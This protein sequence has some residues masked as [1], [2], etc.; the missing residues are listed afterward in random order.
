M[1]ILK[2]ID[3]N[4]TYVTGLLSIALAVVSGAYKLYTAT[5]G[6]PVDLSEDK[7]LLI[8][9]LGMIGFRSAMKKQEQ[10]KA[11]VTTTS[12]MNG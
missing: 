7:T 10:P 1:K 3:G 8:A 9:G 2:A 4:K 5:E 6:Q 11:Q 12:T